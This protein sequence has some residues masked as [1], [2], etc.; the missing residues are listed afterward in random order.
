M[1]PIENIEHILMHKMN[2]KKPA[3]AGFFNLSILLH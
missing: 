1:Q 3:K 2:T